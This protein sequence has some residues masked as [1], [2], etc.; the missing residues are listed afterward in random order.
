MW[1]IDGRSI[2]YTGLN[3]IGLCDDAIEF[4]YSDEGDLGE[5]LKSILENIGYIKRAG[6]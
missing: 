3:N 6:D 1:W 5:L 4:E 2:P